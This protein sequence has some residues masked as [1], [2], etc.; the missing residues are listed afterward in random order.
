MLTCKVYL[1]HLRN[2]KNRKNIRREGERY[3]DSIIWVLIVFELVHSI[4]RHITK[5]IIS[6]MSVTFTHNHFWRILVFLAYLKNSPRLLEHSYSI[7]C[8]S[9]LEKRRKN[10]A[11]THHLIFDG[12]LTNQ[13]VNWKPSLSFKV[14][15]CSK[16]TFF[17]C[18]TIQVS[19]RSDASLRVQSEH[20]FV[21]LLCWLDSV[22]KSCPY[23]KK[24]VTAFAF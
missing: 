3:D 22:W 15:V 4:V 11:D 5:A 19:K 17:A 9:M 13:K 20:F 2:S 24:L 23:K 21:S 10:K 1:S 14:T 8:N 7:G 18:F 6:R 16:A 12:Q